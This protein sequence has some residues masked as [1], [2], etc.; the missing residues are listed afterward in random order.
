MAKIYKSKA[1]LKG[2]MDF[3]LAEQLE[4]TRGL[5]PFNRHGCHGRRQDMFYDSSTPSRDTR[6]KQNVVSKI[7]EVV[8]SNA[9]T[10]QRIVGDNI[11]VVTKRKF[12]LNKEI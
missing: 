4:N 11:V 1:D 3:S 2:L 7:K 12:N 5:N 10:D 6:R 9:F 8:T